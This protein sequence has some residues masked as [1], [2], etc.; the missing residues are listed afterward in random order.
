MNEQQ[1]KQMSDIAVATEML[2]TAKT[3]VASL[4]AAITETANPDLRKTLRSQLNRAIQTQEEIS[5]YMISKGYYHPHNVQEQINLDLQASQAVLGMS[6]QSQTQSG[7]TN[8]QS[9]YC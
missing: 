4:A 2:L 7:S 9:Q 1:K 6:Q 5:S 3:G 8:T